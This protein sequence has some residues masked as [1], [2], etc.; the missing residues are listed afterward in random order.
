MKK[1]IKGK[2]GLVAYLGTTDARTVQQ[3]I[4]EG[5]TYAREVYHAMA[6]Q[7]GKWIGK[8][9]VILKGKV[10]R[11]VLTGGLAYDQEFLVPWIKEMVS[12]I[13]PVEV[14][15]GGDEERALAES[16]LRVI[17]KQEIAKTYEAN[18]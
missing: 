1:K 6:Y 7:I 14:I 3:R 16:A 5:D 18:G 13:A 11:V 4:R 2:G 8:T 10:D 17:A 15:P 12:F 9:S